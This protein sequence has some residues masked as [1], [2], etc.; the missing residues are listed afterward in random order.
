MW[1]RYNIIQFFCDVETC[2]EAVTVEEQVDR[3][4][5]KCLYPGMEEI[6]DI[7]LDNHIPFS[8]DGVVELT[9]EDNVVI[10]SAAMIIDDPKIAIDPIEDTDKAVFNEKGYKIISQNEFNIELI[11]KLK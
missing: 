11:K 8:Y 1:R 7:L 2:R 4:E 10:A 9:D 5:I 6:V 3:D